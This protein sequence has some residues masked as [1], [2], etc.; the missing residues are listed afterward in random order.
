MQC[1]GLPKKQILPEFR[2]P[3]VETILDKTY[4][5]LTN[6]DILHL[7]HARLCATCVSIGKPEA[8]VTPPPGSPLPSTNTFHNNTTREQVQQPD[9][10]ASNANPNPNSGGPQ[11]TM[12]TLAEEPPYAA[13]GNDY[14]IGPLASFIA[15]K[16]VS[17]I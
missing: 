8:L 1:A 14:D 2:S 17:Q 16:I 4:D 12:P 6:E 10:S 3:L 15:Q 9:A 5:S 13:I 11:L 7:V